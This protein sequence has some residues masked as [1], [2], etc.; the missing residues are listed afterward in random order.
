MSFSV[1]LAARQLVEHRGAPTEPSPALQVLFHQSWWSHFIS[2][3]C[4]TALLALVSLVLS[5][6]TCSPSPIPLGS[7]SALPSISICLAVIPCV[8]HGCLPKKYTA[9]HAGIS[10]TLG[11]ISISL[12]CLGWG[13]EGHTWCG[14]IVFIGA[15]VLEVPRDMEGFATWGRQ[16]LASVTQQQCQNLGSAAEPSVLMALNCL[17]QGL[18]GTCLWLLPHPSSFTDTMDAG[19]CWSPSTAPC[20]GVSRRDRWT[21]LCELSQAGSLMPLK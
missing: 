12:C 13:R 5:Q 15:M 1:P 10:A 7:P 4:L 11:V 21:F 6:V 18:S 17:G 8:P 16:S 3:S 14:R 19:G 2:C 20:P 9:G